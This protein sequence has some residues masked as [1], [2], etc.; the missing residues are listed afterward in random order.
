MA[1]NGQ[2]VALSENNVSSVPDLVRRIFGYSYSDPKLYDAGSILGEYEGFLSMTP[3]GDARALLLLC[4]SLP[5][6]HVLEVAELLADPELSEIVAGEI[7]KQFIELLRTHLWE[8]AD[9]HGLHTVFSIEVTEHRL[10]QRLSKYMGFIPA[11]VYL[12]YIPGFKR[13]LLAGTKERDS[14][15]A[16]ALETLAQR[17][18][19]VISIRP[20]RTRTPKQIVALPARYEQL[21]REIYVDFRLAVDYISP[22]LRHAPGRIES[23]VDFQRGIAFIFVLEAGIDTPERVLERL[24]HYR[25][26]FVELI[27]IV[28]PLSGDDINAII[29]SLENA[30]CRYAAVFPQYIDGPA[31][32]MQSIDARLLA[33]I[34]PDVISPRAARILANQI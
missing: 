26:S 4:R 23:K 21:I 22:T 33:P 27:H 2:V 11:G 19:M 14:A 17:R 9:H 5:S 6:P 34:P 10:T 29:E 20:F 8:L 31:L 28:L 18:T 30:G 24:R 7:I 3:A 12:G 32:V 1:E 16:P 15:G 13:Q 25:E